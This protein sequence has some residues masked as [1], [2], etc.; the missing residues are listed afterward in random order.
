MKVKTKIELDDNDL[1]KIVAERFGVSENNV[2]F[3]IESVTRG[4]GPME[5]TDHIAACVVEKDGDDE[6][7]KL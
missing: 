2:R 4:Y 7:C 3:K 6:L 5:T 1:K